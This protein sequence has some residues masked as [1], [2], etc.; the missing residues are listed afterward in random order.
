MDE[1]YGF[2]VERIP[3]GFYIFSISGG[4]SGPGRCQIK[5]AK[6]GA[7]EKGL[8]QYKCSGQ[9]K[10]GVEDRCFS[11]QQDLKARLDAENIHEAQQIASA[12]H[13]PA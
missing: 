2:L 13:V 12:R 5:M 10:W 4:I 8:D 11:E 9:A 1:A 3:A 7:E 6:D